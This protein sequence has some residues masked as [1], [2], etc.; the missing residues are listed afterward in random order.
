MSTERKFI[1]VEE[2]FAKWREDPEFLTAYDALEDEFA[3]ASALIDARAAANLTQ[4]ELARR[5]GTTQ[6]VIARMEGGKVMPSSRTLA[7]LA[8]ATGTR[9]RITFEPAP[10]GAVRS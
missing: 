3:L 10:S 8:R 5:M 2:S 6:P 1:P 9:L 7:K 4:E